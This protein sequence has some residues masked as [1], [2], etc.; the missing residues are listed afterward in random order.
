MTELTVAARL[1]LSLSALQCFDWWMS[2]D[3]LGAG[4]AGTLFSPDGPYEQSGNTLELRSLLDEY[5]Q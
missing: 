4:Q 5:F 1:T 3:M 2:I